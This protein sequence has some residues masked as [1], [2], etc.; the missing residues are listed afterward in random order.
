MGVGSEVYGAIM[1]DRLG[2]G[3]ELKT[4]YFNQAVKNIEAGLHSKATGDIGYLPLFS[5]DEAEAA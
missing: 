5:D 2:I 3:V 4:S 1:A